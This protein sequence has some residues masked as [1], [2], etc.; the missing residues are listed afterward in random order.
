MFEEIDNNF[1]E[2]PELAPK[3]KRSN[4]SKLLL[5][6]FLVLIIFNSMNMA[7]YWIVLSFIGVVAF[8]EFGHFIGMKFS[9]YNEPNFMFYS[10]INN[11]NKKEGKPISQTMKILTLQLGPMPGLIIGCVL[12]YN[13]IN[14]T[15]EFM[16]VI[17]LLLMAVNVFSLL[18]IDPLDGGKIIQQ[19]FFPK[20]V[21]P[22]LYFVLISS[23]I[24]IVV[25]FLSGFYILMGLGFL[26]GLKVR[27]IQKSMFI[28]EELDDQSINYNQDYSALTNRDYWKMRNVFLDFNPRLNSIIPSRFEKWENEN[29]LSA[30]IKSLLKSEVKLDAGPILIVVNALIYIACLAVPFYLVDLNFEFLQTLFSNIEL[31]V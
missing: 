17:S 31:N 6:G 18:P 24:I 15:N 2:K 8:H 22:Y 30:Q 7:N 20:A 3:P 12:F 5:V 11:K 14:N 1:P 27:N 28:Y 13:G 26:M 23:I 16:I 10:L 29:L 19:L 9:G 25:S 4:S 21:K